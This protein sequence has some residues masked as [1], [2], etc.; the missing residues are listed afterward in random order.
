MVMAYAQEKG[1][2]RAAD[3]AALLGISPQRAR[4]MS[5]ARL[6]G[7]ISDG[8]KA[9][10]SVIVLGRRL[11]DPFALQHLCNRLNSFAARLDG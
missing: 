6:L 9:S 3:V 1:M 8:C 10:G 5:A 4:T 2:F 7:W 11:T